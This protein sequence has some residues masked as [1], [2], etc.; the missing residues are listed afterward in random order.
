MGTSNEWLQVLHT[1][2]LI[3]EMQNVTCVPHA[4]A[5]GESLKAEIERV[6]L[7]GLP[8]W[9]ACP[10]SSERLGSLEQQNPRVSLLDGFSEHDDAPQPAPNDD[11]VEDSRFDSEL[12]FHGLEPIGEGAETT[13]GRVRRRADRLP[14]TAA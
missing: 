4:L 9:D 12:V 14:C 3:D 6:V 1:R 8:C 11:G 13:R 10:Q 7:D 2:I 5:C